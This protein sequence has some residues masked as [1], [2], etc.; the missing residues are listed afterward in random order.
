MK[1]VSCSRVLPV[2][3]L[4][5]PMVHAQTDG[6]AALQRDLHTQMP[7]TKATSDRSG[8]VTAGTVL[9]LQKD[10]LTVYPSSLPAAPSSSYKN[11]KLSQG[12]GDALAVDMVDGAGRPGG[13]AAIPKKKLV[14]GEKFWLI[15]TQVQKDKVELEVLTEPYDDGRY[16]GVIKIPFAKGA[17]PSSEEMFRMIAEVVTAQPPDPASGAPAAPPSSPAGA[18][19]DSGSASIAGKYI[20]KGK[21][22]DFVDLASNGTFAMHQDEKDASGSYAIRGET[23]ILTS[24]QWGNGEARG[25]IVGSTMVDANGSVWEKQSESAY[26]LPPIAPPPP[27]ADTPLPAPKTISLGQTK[28]EVTASFG[29]PQKIVK[30]ASKEIDSYPDMK[31]TFVNGKVTDVQ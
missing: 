27:P 26:A 9:V 28:D 20:R 14:A 1:K 17:T 21:S 4:A 23:L 13:S 2:L 8:V 25:K 30:L 7:L 15:A 6:L 29:P 11:G 16:F 19:A 24:P 5:A 31:V 22:S 18:A 12:F 10:G 3:L